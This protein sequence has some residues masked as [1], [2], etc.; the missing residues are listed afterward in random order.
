MKP[1]MIA[2]FNLIAK[3][4]IVIF[5]DYIENVPFYSEID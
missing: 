1:F 4:I 3:D 5:Y 2:A